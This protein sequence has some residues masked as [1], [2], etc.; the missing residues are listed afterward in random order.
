MDGYKITAVEQDS[1][2]EFIDLR[3]I[4]IAKSAE[5]ALNMTYGLE[6][7]IVDEGPHLVDEAR[8]LGMRNRGVFRLPETGFFD[9]RQVPPAWKIGQFAR[10]LI[11]RP[12]QAI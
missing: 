8:G 6:R 12:P 2:N 4:V 11:H 1:D 7:F 9:S 3:F 5:D 10:R